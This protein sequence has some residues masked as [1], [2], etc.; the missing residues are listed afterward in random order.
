MNVAFQKNGNQEISDFS[1]FKTTRK[2]GR[3]KQAPT[4]KNCFEQSSNSEFQVLNSGIF[5]GEEG[6]CIPMVSSPTK[7]LNGRKMVLVS[8][9]K[10]TFLQEK[11]L[12]SGE[13]NCGRASRGRM[14]RVQDSMVCA[15]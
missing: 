1:A 6:S 10:K 4:R 2:S 11:T 8:K 9:K 14:A 3:K 7:K 13:K 15:N 12:E 5:L